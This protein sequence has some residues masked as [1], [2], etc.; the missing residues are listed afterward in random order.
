MAPIK[1]IF[2][3]DG[4]VLN[5]NAVRGIQWP[6]LVAEF[7]PPILGGDP[8]AWAEANRVAVPILWQ[9]YPTLLGTHGPSRDFLEEHRRYDLDWLQVMAERVG[10]SLPASADER[11]KLSR[12]A[13]IYITRRIRAAFPGAVAAIRELHESGYILRTA[14]GGASWEIEGYVEGMGVR[15]HFHTL[16]GPDFVGISKGGPEY[17]HAIFEH[18]RVDPA[19]ALVVDDSPRAV[20]WATAAGARALLVDREGIR[21]EGVVHSL[22]EVPVWLRTFAAA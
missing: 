7:F 14:S 18:A 5:D 6:A 10:V 12:D 11:L 21:G 19:E 1:H 20:G 4:G 2:L 22:A 8:A 13:A 3:D 15:E 16:Y 9:N 17:Y